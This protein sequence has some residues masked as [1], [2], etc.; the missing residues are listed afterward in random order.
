MGREKTIRRT[1]AKLKLSEKQSVILDLKPTPV[2]VS[3]C[4]AFAAEEDEQ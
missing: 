3:V 1:I 2:K 4:T